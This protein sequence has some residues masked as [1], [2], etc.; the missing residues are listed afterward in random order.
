MPLPEQAYL[1]AVHCLLWDRPSLL[2]RLLKAFPSASHLWN[3]SQKAILQKGFLEKEASLFTEAKKTF[4]PEKAYE[5]L[6]RKNIDL[7][8]LADKNYPPLLKA[9]DDPPFLLYC[10]GILDPSPLVLAMVGTRKAS[11]YG[12]A[13]ARSLISGLSG[14]EIVIVS[15]LALGIDSVVH[16][17]ALEVSLKTI[18]VLGTGVDQKSI[19][20]S[21]NLRLAE[22]I[23]EAG[24][25]IISEYPPGTP[26]KKWHF[27]ARNRI[28]AGVSHGVIVIEAPKKSGALITAQCALEQNREVLAVPGSIFHENSEG[29]HWLIQSGATPVISAE[30]IM[31]IF[32]IQK[33]S[34][35]SSPSLSSEEEKIVQILSASPLHIDH[36]IQ[37]SGL[38]PSEVQSLL[39]VLELKNIIQHL[40]GGVYYLTNVVK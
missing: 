1:H 32:H 22:K 11:P 9:I 26:G 25:A 30:D 33:K 10:R 2:R 8:S 28:I 17:C 38:Q 3:A 39:A 34:P 6:A 12:K 29:V 15:G 21:T 23:I 31:N 19:F 16:Q 4:S 18:A 35:V 20:P 14:L 7:V 36:I 24:G 5:D 40:G 27:P 13:V 37:K